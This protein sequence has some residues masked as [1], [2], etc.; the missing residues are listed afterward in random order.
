MNLPIGFDRTGE[1]ERLYRV[2]A[3]PTTFFIDA[4][5]VIRS[6]VIGGPMR[7]ALLR[8]EAEALLRE[9]SP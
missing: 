8:A 5:G 3:L 2:R 4:E 6:V 1:I 7:E 9:P